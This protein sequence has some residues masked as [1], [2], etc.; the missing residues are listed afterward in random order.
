MTYPILAPALTRAALDYLGVA[1]AKSDLTLLDNLI[2]SYTR[3]VPWESASR[4]A[5]R[6]HKPDTADCPRWPDVFWLSALQF[7]TGGTCFESNYAFFSLLRSLGYDGYLTINNMG[8][9]IGCHTA[10]VLQLDG[11][12]WLVD[13]GLPLFTAIPLNREQ[14]TQRTNP[15]LNYTVRPLDDHRYQV[16]R[17]PHPNPICFTLIDQPVSDADYRAATTNDYGTKGLFLDAV[18]INK[19]INGQIWRFSSRE[20]PYHVEQ[21]DRGLRTDMPLTADLTGG[22]SQYFGIN[23]DIIEAALSA[24]S[25]EH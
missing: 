20:Q 17:E 7:G 25:P 16:E 11:Q 8:S 6:A 18:I 4:V 19:V 1:A 21:F 24:L 2:S 9:T 12:P 22:L 5:R 10:I 14:P 23:R 15:L 13:V 3:C